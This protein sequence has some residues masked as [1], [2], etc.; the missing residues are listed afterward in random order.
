MPCAHF[1]VVG[2]G[3]RARLYKSPPTS[4][5]SEFIFAQLHL[6]RGCFTSGIKFSAF[7]KNRIYTAAVIDSVVQQLK[8]QKN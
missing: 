7:F 2:L 8:K 1:Y 3:R 4:K 5:I 6:K